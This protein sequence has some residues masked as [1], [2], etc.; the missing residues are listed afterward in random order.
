MPVFS[1][2]PAS[3]TTVDD[4]TTPSFLEKLVMKKFYLLS[5]LFLGLMQLN[6]YAYEG[7]GF[8]VLSETVEH[9][10]GVTGKFVS[11]VSK[12]T[13]GIALSWSQAYDARGFANTNVVLTGSHSISVTNYTNQNQIYNY[14]YELNCDGQYFRK[15]DR[16]EVRPGGVVNQSGSSFLTTYH[17]QKG[18]FQINASTAVSGESSHSHISGGTLRVL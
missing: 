5:I 17:R 11:S 4:P 9:S 7:H 10:P 14:K 18:L 15:V 3:H 12:K 16:I 6:A 13:P 1:S 2:Y 8:R